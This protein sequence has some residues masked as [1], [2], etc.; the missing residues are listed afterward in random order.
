M[1]VDSEYE[2]ERDVTDIINVNT[3]DNITKHNKNDNGD[4][5]MI[6]GKEDNTFRDK[7][8]NNNHDGNNDLTIE[9]N[10]NDDCITEE[11]EEEEEEEENYVIEDINDNND[12]GNNNDIQQ[13]SLLESWEDQVKNVQTVEKIEDEIIVH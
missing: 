2:Y 8:E 11:E 1:E 13:R 6:E 10:S 12:D 9:D 5:C 7:E 3:I 4:D